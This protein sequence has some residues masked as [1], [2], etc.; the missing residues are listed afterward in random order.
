MKTKIIGFD[1]AVTE[2]GYCVCIYD[3]K[4]FKLTIL[5]TDVIKGSKFMKQVKENMILNR[6]TNQFCMLQLFHKTFKDLIIEHKPDV[7]VTETPFIHRFITAYASLKLLVDRLRLASYELLKKDIVEIA[8]K[9][10][11]RFVKSG[12]A[13]KED[14]KEIFNKKDI[15]FKI[16]KEKLS[17]HE[18]DSIGVVYGYIK[19]EERS[20][21]FY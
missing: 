8:P 13:S 20:V 3:H 6:F 12:T 7:I 21:T 1:P 4:T 14:M 5:K 17:E 10:V 11:K 19:R 9:E 15:I 2:T 16:N 18:I